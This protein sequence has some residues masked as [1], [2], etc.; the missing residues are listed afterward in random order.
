MGEHSVT[1]GATT[2][3]R[4]ERGRVH[5]AL[6]L[7]TGPDTDPGPPPAVTIDGSIVTVRWPAGPTDTVTLPP[8]PP[9]DDR[10]PSESTLAVT[11][12]LGRH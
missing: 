11:V 5:A 6:V 3:G 12:S 7:L 1:P 10:D 8:M 4:V 2:E 9:V